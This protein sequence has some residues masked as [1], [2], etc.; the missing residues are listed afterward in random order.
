MIDIMFTTAASKCKLM[1]EPESPTQHSYHDIGIEEQGK[2][3]TNYG[4]ENTEVA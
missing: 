3:S 4:V 2:A 1:P